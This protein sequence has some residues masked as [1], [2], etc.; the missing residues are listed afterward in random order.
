MFTV[1]GAFAINWGTAMELFKVAANIAGLILAI[2]SVQILRVNTRFL[3]NELQPPLWRKIAMVV[4]ALVYSGMFV[5]V[6]R[7][8]T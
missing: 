1:W 6:V 5:V 3:P 8:Q 7:S 4:I 2:G